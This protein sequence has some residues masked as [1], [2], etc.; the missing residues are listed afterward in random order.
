MTLVKKILSLIPTI[1]V[2]GIL[3]F[4]GFIAWNSIH[5]ELLRQC[6]SSIAGEIVEHSHQ[7]ENFPPADN[8]LYVLSD[9]Q[10]ASVFSEIKPPQ[11]H[12]AGTVPLDITNRNLRIAIRGNKNGGFLIIV[13]SRGFDNISGT[14]DDIID[15]RDEK[16]P[17]Q[18]Q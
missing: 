18:Q 7:I 9:G 5:R 11:C 8:S 4:F 2:A 1:C 13:W 12:F 6:I 3:V 10:T 16:V 15:P 14:E 17:D